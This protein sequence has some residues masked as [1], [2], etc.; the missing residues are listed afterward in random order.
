[1]K[2]KIFF[3]TLILFFSCINLFC[4]NKKNLNGGWIIEENYQRLKNNDEFFTTNPRTINI[5]D[6]DYYYFPGSILINVETEFP[7]IF[8]NSELE[9]DIKKIDYLSEN[10]FI[11]EVQDKHNPTSIGNFRIT[12]LDNK[13]II[14]EIEDGNATFQKNIRYLPLGKGYKY[15]LIGMVK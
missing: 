13:C 8:I 7:Y 9:F 12:I 3:I 4:T 11:F 14:L 1:M 6:S 15:F 5:G 2:T 10:I